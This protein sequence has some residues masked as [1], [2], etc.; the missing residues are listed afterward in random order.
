MIK[1]IELAAIQPEKGNSLTRLE[2]DLFL[3][4]L[5]WKR[6]NQSINQSINTKFFR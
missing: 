3:F 2:E 5:F 1:I 4:D 6:I